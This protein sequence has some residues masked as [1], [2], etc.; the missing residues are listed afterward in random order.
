M[1]EAPAARQRAG[2]KTSEQLGIER[3]EVFCSLSPMS[4]LHDRSR[5]P[6]AD[7]M[8]ACICVCGPVLLYLWGL[9]SRNIY[10]MTDELYGVNMLDHRHLN[11][12]LMVKTLF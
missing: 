2:T 12:W 3:E 1:K 8:H 4:V 11:G 6:A 7:N 9:E 5:G 10:M